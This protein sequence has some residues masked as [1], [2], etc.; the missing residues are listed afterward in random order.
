MCAPSSVLVVRQGWRYKKWVLLY[1][2]WR[3][4]RPL[5][6]WSPAVREVFGELRGSDVDTSAERLYV[7]IES[8]SYQNKLGA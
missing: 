3:F 2:F 4:G 5:R 6:P 7:L 1:M 8:Y